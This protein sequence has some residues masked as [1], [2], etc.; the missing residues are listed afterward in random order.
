M[1]PK[2]F[3]PTRER[4]KRRRLKS[5]RE[6]TS[7]DNNGESILSTSGPECTPAIPDPNA[8]II[9]PLTDAQ[10]LWKRRQQLK[11][12]LKAGV[13]KM[14]AKKKKRLDKYIETKLKKEEKAALVEK[15]AEIRVDTSLFASTKSIGASKESKK[16]QIKRALL[17]E[18]AGI[19]LE[20]NTEILYQERQLVEPDCLEDVNDQTIDL[21]KES[22]ARHL[23]GTSEPSMAARR[24]STSP[25]CVV[26]EATTYHPTTAQDRS[27]RP[28]AVGV[29]VGAG[30]KR[31]LDGQDSGVPIIKRIK[32]DRKAKRIPVAV[33]DP[34]YK[35]T[36]ESDIESEY[37]TTFL[38]SGSPSEAEEEEWKGFSDDN[39]NNDGAA[40]GSSLEDS[41]EDFASETESVEDDDEDHVNRLKRGQSKKANAFKEWALA[42]R[43]ST[44]DGEMGVPKSN[45]QTSMEMKSK[46]VHVPRSREEDMTP[47]PEELA[48]RETERKVC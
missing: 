27:V 32:K 30:L 47:P 24:Y 42:Q 22:M 9:V 36:E 16:Q 10:K 17:E 7:Q 26:N 41:D 37:S 28:F 31:P 1:P 35:S 25:E 20:A 29:A 15:L 43:K 23:S 18:Q 5:Q 39:T 34:E 48:V 8:D 21:T 46:I 38:E 14:S 2:S 12:E 4:K 33:K 45:I 3:K 11:E 6:N 40:S 13:P 44:I 19:N